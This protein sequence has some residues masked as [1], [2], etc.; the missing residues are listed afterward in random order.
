MATLATVSYSI[1][2]HPPYSP[3]LANKGELRMPEILN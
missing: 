2:H 1:M 3:D